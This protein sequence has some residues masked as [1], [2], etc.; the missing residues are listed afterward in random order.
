M[1]HDQLCEC[2]GIEVFLGSARYAEQARRSHI[3]AVLAEHYRQNNNGTYDIEK[4]SRVSKRTSEWSTTRA[5]MIADRFA[6]IRMDDDCGTDKLH[7]N[8]S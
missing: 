8:S 6:A 2:L 5:W 7:L 3:A 4:L 1:T